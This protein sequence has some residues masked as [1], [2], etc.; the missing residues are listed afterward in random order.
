[1]TAADRARKHWSPRV[2]AFRRGAALWL[3][4]FR[5]ANRVERPPAPVVL[6]PV[7]PVENIILEG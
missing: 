3:K 5:E 7:R 2:V 1:M 4:D 6:L